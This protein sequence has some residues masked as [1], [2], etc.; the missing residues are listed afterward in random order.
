MN[1]IPITWHRSVS[2]EA[3]AQIKQVLDDQDTLEAVLAWASTF[4]PPRLVGDIV[5]Q[6]EFNLDVIV[7]VD[8]GLYLVYAAS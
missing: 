1:T 5:T 3:A 4:D 7:P 2:P 6:D 8:E